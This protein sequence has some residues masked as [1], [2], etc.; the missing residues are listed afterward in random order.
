MIF[1]QAKSSAWFL[2]GA[3]D[4]TQAKTLWKSNKRAWEFK[5][6]SLGIRT[7]FS[8]KIKIILGI[9]DVCN[10]HGSQRSRGGLQRWQPFEQPL[11]IKFYACNVFFFLFASHVLSTFL[12]LSTLE[13]KCNVWNAVLYL[14]RLDFPLILWNNKWK[15]ECLE[16]NNPT[17]PL[18]SVRPL[19]SQ[20]ENW[21]SRVKI[22]V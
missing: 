11:K 21:S 12:S 8:L 3:L 2:K 16:L 18:E 9:P 14:E 19:N 20:W 6:H 10:V 1:K 5:N 7:H 13:G 22:E 17:L 4:L 15:L